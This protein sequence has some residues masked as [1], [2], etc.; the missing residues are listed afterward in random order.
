MA[1]RILPK[2]SRTPGRASPP[3]NGKATTHRHHHASQREL[4][5]AQRRSAQRPRHAGGALDSPRRF[6]TLV[7]IITDPVYLTEPFI[8]TTNWELTP[9]QAIDPYPCEVA[10]EVERPAGSVPHHL[11]GTNTFLSEFAGRF[12]LPER[13]TRGGAETMY[14]EYRTAMRKVR[15]SARHSRTG[16]TRQEAPHWRGIHVQRVRGNIYMLSGAGGNITVD[17]EAR[18]S[19]WWTPAWPP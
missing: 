4:R 16:D 6:L 17:A 7:S 12:S 8:R 14:P 10:E 18:E 11:P 19:C 15:G 9:Q 2:T 5:A 13:A 1:A 3:E